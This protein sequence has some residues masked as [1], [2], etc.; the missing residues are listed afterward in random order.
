[1]LLK[2]A[3]KILN[4]HKKDLLGL[5][6]RSLFLFGSVA[7]NKASAKS[8]IDILVDFDV[9]KGLFGFVGLK[10]YLE[11]LLHCDVD[12]VTKSALHPALKKQILHEAKN[13]F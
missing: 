8:D 4:A 9:K 7:R 3:K 1:M 2:E 10:N 12:L 11:E 6:V 13:V 5:G